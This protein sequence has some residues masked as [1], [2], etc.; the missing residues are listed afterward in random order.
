MPWRWTCSPRPTPARLGAHV[1]SGGGQT[2]FIVGALHSAG[3]LAVIALSSWHN[4]ANVSTAVP[5]L[6]GPVTSFQHSAIATEQGRAP[7]WGRDSI[8]QAQQ[9]LDQAAHPQARDSLRD[10]GRRLGLPLR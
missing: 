1:Y 7:L 6:S 2:D 10:A 4:R 5:L 3:G 8:D 9:I